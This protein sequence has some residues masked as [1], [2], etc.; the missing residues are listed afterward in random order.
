MNGEEFK[1]F[2]A[3]MTERWDNHDTRANANSSRIDESLKCIFKKLDSIRGQKEICMKESRE[4]T[5]K[6][7]SYSKAYT[8][9][10]VA[11]SLG[12]PVTLFILVRLFEYLIRK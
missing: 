6:A 1:I 7:E 9:K 2:Q 8:S 5:D 10:L 11:I 4:Y 12:I 3:T